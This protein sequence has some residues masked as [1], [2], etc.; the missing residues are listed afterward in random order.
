M[1]RSADQLLEEI[2]EFLIIY[3]KS[4]KVG[5]NSFVK[6]TDLHISQM[7]QLLK[8]H[9]MLKPEVIAFVQD[10]PRFIRRFKTSTSVNQNVYHG[11][12]KGQINWHRTLN[13]PARIS[14]RDKTIFS[15]NERNRE[16]AIKENLVLLET[17]QTLH[18]I[19]F[20]DIDSGHFEKYEWFREWSRL[21]QS[22][23]N[24]FTKNVYLSKVGS[25]EGKVT[26]RMIIDTLKQRNPLYN[27]AASILQEYRRIMD[28]DVNQT[29]IEQL[30]RETFVYPEEE[31]VLF[32]LY[33]VVKLIKENSTDS[34]LELMDGR[35]N[36][37]AAWEDDTLVYHIYHDSAGSSQ[38]HFRTST[39]EVRKHGHPFLDR[40]LDS[41]EQSTNLA[42]ELF[43]RGFDT[44]TYWSGRPDILVEVYDKASSEL[45]KL[46][47]GEVKHTTRV[48]YAITGLR[49]LVDY[50]KLVRNKNGSYLDE[51]VR[52]QGMLFT[53][54]LE[55]YDVQEKYFGFGNEQ[56]V[57]RN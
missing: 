22:L 31:D 24:V 16:Y 42:K 54:Q 7:D 17:I 21:K 13:E 50:M 37:V 34:E 2:S 46:V 11:Q 33:W 28:G 39:E 6:K 8:I 48:E 30:L 49:E 15:V 36:L 56:V 9:F 45:K 4:G 53:E 3:L 40:K 5:L 47:I 43:G 55:G 51:S 35:N 27:K 52:V 18:K 14:T 57:W 10:L 12:V 26:K 44:S 32:E 29:E 38:I 23:H 41:V 25:S 19:L 1:K 20:K